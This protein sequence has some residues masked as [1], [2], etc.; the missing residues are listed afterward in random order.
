MTDNDGCVRFSK[1]SWHYYILNIV[2]PEYLAWGRLNLC[3]Y[4]RHTFVAIPLFP[5]ILVWNR[6]PYQITDHKD[7]ARGIGIYFIIITFVSILLDASYDE[8]FWLFFVLGFFG[9]LGLA[10]AFFGMVMGIVGLKDYIDDR[11]DRE[12]KEHKTRGLIKTYF[13]SKHEKIC[14]CVKFVEDEDE[15]FDKH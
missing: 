11:I 13:K 5:L 7:I 14:P 6:L 10:V 12:Y 4:L 8:P 15:K 1:S 9:G 3:P 2:F